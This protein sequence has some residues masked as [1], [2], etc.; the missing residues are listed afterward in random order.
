MTTHLKSSHENSDDSD[1]SS[2]TFDNYENADNLEELSNFETIFQAE[3][4]DLSESLDFLN[5][6]PA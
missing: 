4:I 2:Q 5:A 3:D 6:V 1:L